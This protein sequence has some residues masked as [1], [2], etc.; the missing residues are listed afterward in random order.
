MSK[1]ALGWIGIFLGCLVGV[2]LFR[3]FLE[4]SSEAPRPIP[5]GESQTSSSALP[6]PEQMGRILA[7]EP[8]DP[9]PL[10]E[11]PAQQ[12]LQEVPSPAEELSVQEQEEDE[13]IRRLE[14]RGI[15]VY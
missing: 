1:S 12:S 2:Y 4:S 5:G 15:V 8:L 14:E 9:L 10:L 7:D 11:Q 13:K 3:P 6:T